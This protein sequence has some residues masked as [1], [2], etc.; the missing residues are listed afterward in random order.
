MSRNVLA[1]IRIRLHAVLVFVT[2]AE[3]APKSHIDSATVLRQ[4]PLS[5]LRNMLTAVG[6]CYVEF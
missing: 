6:G 5:P 2:L 1:I 3:R 4:A